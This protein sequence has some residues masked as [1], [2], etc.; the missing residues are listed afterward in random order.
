MERRIALQKR[1]SVES[2]ELFPKS[3]LLASLKR[4]L[5]EKCGKCKTLK[6]ADCKFGICCCFSQATLTG[7]KDTVKLDSPKLSPSIPVSVTSRA[8][9]EF[10][11]TVY[12]KTNEAFLDVCESKLLPQVKDANL[13]KKTLKTGLVSG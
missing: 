12:L 4:Y 10:R 13:T 3:K 2:E 11:F 1:H 5:F 8:D 9:K 7:K 6:C